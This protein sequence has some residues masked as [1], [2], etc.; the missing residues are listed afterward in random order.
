MEVT[1][2]G[3]LFVIPE[4]D[5]PCGLWKSY[6]NKLKFEVGK[7][8]AKMIWLLT[9]GELKN[10]SCPTNPEFNKWLKSNDMEVAN[11]G[12]RAIADLSQIG[13]NVL[14]LGKKLTNLLS[15]GLPIVTVIV[16]VI[17]LI[18]IWNTVKESSVID[19][20]EITPMGRTAKLAMASKLI[21]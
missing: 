10:S 15:N 5:S 18:L 20:A 8:H 14:G 9:W 1:V 7:D 17:G 3:K 21:K 13:G 2:K 11:A 4:K 12:Q 6:F 16:V 19:V